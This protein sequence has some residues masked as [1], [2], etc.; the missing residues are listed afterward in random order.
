MHSSHRLECSDSPVHMQR[1][2]RL[3]TACTMGMR[4]AGSAM[5]A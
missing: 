2:L 3:G 4:P 1:A 5:T